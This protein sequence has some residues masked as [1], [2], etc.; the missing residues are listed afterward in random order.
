MIYA[1][2]IGVAS[3]LPVIVLLSSSALGQGD[4]GVSNGK[5]NWSEEVDRQSSRFQ[6]FINDDEA[7]PLAVVKAYKW[8][9]AARPILGDRLCLLYIHEGRP[10]AS[11]KIYP[12]GQS[13]T[14]V[15]ISMSPQ[16][17]VCKQEGDVVWTPPKCELG[18]KKIPGVEHPSTSVTRR[19]SEMKTIA[20]DFSSDM[21]KGEAQRQK[22][23]PGLRLLPTAIYR[24]EVTDSGADGVI[25]GAVFAFVA[26]GGNPEALLLLEAVRNGRELFW[27][28]AFSRRSNAKLTGLHK[29]S[30]VWE[31]E[32]IPPSELGSNTGFHRLSRS[33]D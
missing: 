12:D 21:G 15:F 30:K 23:N 2:S 8:S 11:C 31:V 4:V 24:Y 19:Q 10:Q 14:H 1:R 22:A 6:L 27:Q 9:N 26:D 17:L 7:V 13:I 28:Y 3:L 29:G 5:R 33:V 18:F 32:F 25:D 16:E 20:R